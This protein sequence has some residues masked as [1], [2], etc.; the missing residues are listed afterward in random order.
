MYVQ[1]VVPLL[2]LTPVSAF[3]NFFQNQHQEPVLG[4]EDKVLGSDCNKYVCSDTLA[5]VDSPKECPCPMPALQLRCVLP[6]SDY[7]C[8]SKPAGDF[9][10]KYD[11]ADNWKV[12]AKDDAVRDCGWVTRAWKG[13][14]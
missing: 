3:F 11:G 9:G 6:N 13:A 2:L 1:L 12:D 4:H 8:I 5:C 10:E 7:V 14:I